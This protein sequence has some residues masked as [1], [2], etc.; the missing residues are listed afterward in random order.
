MPEALLNRFADMHTH[1]DHSID[2][3]ASADDMCAAAYQLGLRA[4]DISDHCDVNRDAELHCFER[5]S[6]SIADALRLKN[7][8][9]GRMKVLCGIEIGNPHWNPEIAE[10]CSKID[11]LDCIIGSVHRIRYEGEELITT[12]GDYEHMSKEHISGLV[13]KY[14][15]DIILMIDTVHPDI[16]AHPTYMFRYIVGHHHI[17]LDITEYAD[18]TDRILKRIISDGVALE[19]NTQIMKESIAEYDIYLLERY[20][21]LGGRL[22]TLGSDAHSC[23][24]LAN[25]FIY[26]AKELLRIGFCGACIVEERCFNICKF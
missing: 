5:S 26:A 14:F 15:E 19:V 3:K 17:P 7:E 10:K 9:Q 4:I 22:I 25:S 1:T 16:L 11:G 23:D 12:K 6:A 18:E 20:Y 21:E 2:G 13:R 8:Y 24:R